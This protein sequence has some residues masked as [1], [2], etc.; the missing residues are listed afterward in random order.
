MIAAK[1]CTCGHM[2]M[3]MYILLAECCRIRGMI[4]SL[5]KTGNSMALRLSREMREH[6]GITDKIDVQ[7]VEGAIVLRRPPLG[8]DRAKASALDKLEE[9]LR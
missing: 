7:F 9:A 5:T 6:L 1:S 8:F 4:R 2:V 3:P